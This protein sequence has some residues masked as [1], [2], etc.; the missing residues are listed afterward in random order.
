MLKDRV[1]RAVEGWKARDVTSNRMLGTGAGIL[2]FGIPLSL[3]YLVAGP[4]AG[5]R[6]VSLGFLFVSVVL[7]LYSLW[8]AKAPGPVD[9]SSFDDDPT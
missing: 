1:A 5:D 3:W 9:R 8:E 4:T 7:G 6:L 2:L